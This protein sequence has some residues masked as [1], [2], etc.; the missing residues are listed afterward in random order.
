MRGK[1]Y[2]PNFVDVSDSDETPEVRP[3][4]SNT[5][6]CG[7]PSG[8][9]TF[10][11]DGRTFC[12]CCECHV[13]S[14]GIPADWHKVCMKTWGELQASKAKIDDEWSDPIFFGMPKP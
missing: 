9:Q 1:R 4:P 2:R 8:H 10:L 6:A 12:Q 3:N 5:C 11:P 14:G 13:R 7:K